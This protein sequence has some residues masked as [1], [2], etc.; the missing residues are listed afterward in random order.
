MPNKE[1]YKKLKD[2]GVFC[3]QA[4]KIKTREYAKKYA[5]NNRQKIRIK[6]KL[7]YQKNKNTNSY[8][9]R[10]RRW[11]ANNKDKIKSYYVKCS[12]NFD[13]L[14]NRKKYF[15]EYRKKK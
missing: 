12:N 4:Y 8:K 5:I 13:L 3:T 15:K 7:W 6:N 9:E 1:Q 2:A 14:E 11:K 10:K